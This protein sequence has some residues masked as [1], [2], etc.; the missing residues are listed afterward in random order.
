MVKILKELGILSNNSTVPHLPVLR[1]MLQT[2]PCFSNNSSKLE[3]LAKNFGV[4]IIWVPKFHCELNPIEG[5][6][7]YLK[8]YVRKNN[9]QDYSKFF[10]LIDK[11]IE[12]YLEKNLNIKLWNRFWKAIQMYK[13]NKSYQEVLQTLF[14]AKSDVT[15]SHKKITN[16]PV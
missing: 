4:R 16:V 8:F 13:D 10:G 5:L 11:A 7:C 1:S 14:G 12:V 15:V 9:D 3:F 2:H 6:W